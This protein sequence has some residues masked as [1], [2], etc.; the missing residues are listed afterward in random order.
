MFMEKGSRRYRAT[1]AVGQGRHGEP[2][3]FLARPGRRRRRDRGATRPG[4]G[5]DRHVAAGERAR[6]E[7][8]RHGEERGRKK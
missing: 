1:G 2:R 4:A 5:H 8:R 7:E 6:G 3:R